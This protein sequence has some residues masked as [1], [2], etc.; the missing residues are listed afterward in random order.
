MR[1]ATIVAD[2]PWPYRDQDGPRVSQKIRP[3]TWNGTSGSV[4]SHNRYGSMSIESIC[5]LCPPFEKQSHLYLWTTNS[6]MVEAHQVARAWGFEPKTILTWVKIKGD[7]TPSMKAGWHFRSATE[8]ILFATRGRRVWPGLIRPTA[9]LL[10]R[11]KHSKKPDF[12]YRLAEECSP[13][14][15]LEM[16]ARSTRDGWSVWGN[17]VA[18]SVQLGILES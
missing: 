9:Y 16:F 11:E 17:E 6:F 15:R 7:G 4:S 2:P 3:L 18:S 14:P 12:F 8:H 5:S 13:A 1:F 10:P